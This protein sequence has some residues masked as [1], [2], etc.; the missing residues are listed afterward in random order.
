MEKLIVYSS[1]EDEE[2]DS[3]TDL[4]LR[5][6]QPDPDEHEREIAGTVEPREEQEKEQGQQEQQEQE[7]E[8]E[9]EQEQQ[10]LGTEND[11]YSCE[12]LLLPSSGSEPEELAT[13]EEY[14]HYEEDDGQ[15]KAHEKPQ[16]DTEDGSDDNDD[17][18]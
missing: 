12:E 10:Q 18:E 7:E 15:E 1:S 9:E 13:V 14:L 2:Y 4:F 6:L 11:I 5:Q 3:C 16:S 17:D 8:Q